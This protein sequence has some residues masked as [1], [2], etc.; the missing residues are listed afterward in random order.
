M[1]TCS[2]VYAVN[3]YVLMFM[4]VLHTHTPSL[5][6]IIVEEAQIV[7]SEWGNLFLFGGFMLLTLALHVFL[8]RTYVYVIVGAHNSL[9]WLSIIQC[10]NEVLIV[11][12]H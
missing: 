1:F 11:R 8:A 2:W 7:D 5:I 3:V 4:G 12:D 6:V 9:S 10:D